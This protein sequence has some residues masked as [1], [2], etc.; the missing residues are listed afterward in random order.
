MG[1]ETIALLVGTAVA[2]GSTGASVAQA[3]DQKQEAKSAANDQKQQATALQGQVA[4]EQQRNQDAAAQIAQRTR[5]RAL[6][7]IDSGRNPDVRTGPQGLVPAAPTQ[8][9]MA[10][11][12]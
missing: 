5:Q 2:L 6:Y 7:A 12:A 11:G 10:L 3:Q 8:K 9:K 4:A 1:I